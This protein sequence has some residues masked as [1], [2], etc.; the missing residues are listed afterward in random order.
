MTQAIKYYY[1]IKNLKLVQVFYRFKYILKRNLYEKKGKV[2]FKKLENR[3]EKQT[4][5]INQDSKFILNDRTYY[6]NEID[7]V[8]ENK[9]T[10]L[11]HEIKFTESGID[12][13][14]EE[15]NQGTRLWKLN[16]NY[17]EF[18]FD[19]ALKFNETKDR[20]YLGYIE[21]TIVEWFKQNP[22]GTKGYGK[23]NW[24]SYAISLRIISWIKMYTLLGK[25]FSIEFQSFFI[26]LLWIQITFLSE[27]LE[28]DILGNHLIKNW[29]ALIWGN[30]FFTTTKFN[31][32]IKI[33]EKYIYAQFSEEGM[34]E[35]HSPMYAGIVLED[36]ME[37][38][39]F[40]Q[41]NQKLEALIH[42]QFDNV[43][44]LSN[45]NQ[46]LFFND[47]VNN[48]GIQFGQLN[49]LYL[50]I[51]R[52]KGNIDENH[53]D[54]N[55]F[56]GFKTKME[57]IVFDC[58][59][60][61]GGNQPGHVQCDALS[62]EYFWN[63]RKIF[64]NSGTYEYNS[65]KKRQFSRS[66]ESHNVLKYG[67]FEQSEV[68]GSFRMA[69]HAKVSYK[70]YH[71][72]SE[73]MDVE[74]KVLGYDFSKNITHRRRLIKEKGFL[75]IKDELIANTNK[76]SQL[77]FHLHADLTFDSNNIIEKKTNKK[78]GTIKS[79]NS[80]KIAST[81]FYPEFG[82][83]NNKNTFI[84]FDINPNEEVITEIIFNE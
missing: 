48:N 51:F 27:N 82:I 49:D 83:C 4:I 57:H 71:L 73:K 10:F 39:L 81:E 25:E 47:S 3:F 21:S 24:N 11:N 74:G 66:S 34:H 20:K 61:V 8:L 77:F 75:T 42:K 67:T 16:L 80:S 15:L 62:F 46:Y 63:G 70:V 29:K 22:L 76:K 65:G 52:K 78:I 17:H 54:I 43:R 35:E 38:F 50:K 31:K 44:L 36:L 68:W 56:I 79:S 1:T 6:L 14:S 18:L 41:K 59:K 64:T 9:I 19:I 23:D 53:F 30:Y 40:E 84:V 33:A 60:V 45:K 5:T 7:N 32:T 72:E 28:L 58:A 12:W 2:F 55:G 37:V 69:R 13:H 26:K